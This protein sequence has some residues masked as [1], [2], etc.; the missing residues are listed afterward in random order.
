M[1][2]YC[3]RNKING[4]CYIGLS[5]HYNTNEEFQKSNYWGSGKYLWNAIKKYG[6]GNFERWVILKNIFNLTELY[7]YERLWI[8]KKK[9]KIPVGYNLNNGGMG[10]IGCTRTKEWKNSISRSLIGKKHTRESIDKMRATKERYFKYNSGPR[11]GKKLSENSLLKMKETKRK[12]FEIHS[13]PRKGAVVTEKTRKLQSKIKKEYF[14]THR[15]NRLGK[16]V[17]QESKEKN[18]VAHLGKKHSELSIQLMKEI[19]R[20]TK[21]KLICKEC[22]LQ[23]EA[24]NGN[25]KICN[26]CKNKKNEYKNSEEYKNI[27]KQNYS[28]P[29]KKIC[30]ICKFEFFCNSN[31][32]KICNLCK[33]KEGELQVGGKVFQ[34]AHNQPRG[35]FDS[36][37]CY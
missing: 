28:K 12:Y 26:V 1:I 15:S 36:R 11:L 27:K 9:T 21:Y 29:R 24:N 4:K 37:T 33:S 14:K 6:L 18:R 10:N 25:T 22:G 5:T 17:S 20:K 30:K 7:R 19:R 32:Q 23:F 35:G 3:V 2:I 16:T 8:F 34:L 13:G 31:S